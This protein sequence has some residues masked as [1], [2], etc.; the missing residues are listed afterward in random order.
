MTANLVKKRRLGRTVRLEARVTD[1]QKVLIQRA[2]ALAG[3]SVS[4]FISSSA[5]D[6]AS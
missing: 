3:R 4:Q 2:A 1:A 5:L 6:A